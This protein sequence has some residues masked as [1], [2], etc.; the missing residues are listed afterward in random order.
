MSAVLLS[1][2]ERVPS[3]LTYLRLLLFYFFNF[4]IL[5]QRGVDSKLQQ[6]L[7]FSVLQFK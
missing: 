5:D 1:I 4:L 2:N 6:E 3:L 7:F